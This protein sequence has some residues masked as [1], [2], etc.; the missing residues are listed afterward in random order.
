MRI[1]GIDRELSD[2]SKKGLAWL[3]KKYKAFNS[4]IHLMDQLCK[5]GKWPLPKKA[6]KT[7]IIEIF[8]SKSFWHSHVVGN[9]NNVVGRFPLMVEWLEREDGDLPSDFEVWHMQ[10]SEY[11]FKEL[12]LWIANDG[13]LDKVVKAKLEKAKGKKGKGKNRAKEESGDTEECRMEIDEKVGG[14]KD[15]KLTSSKAKKSHKRK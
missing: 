8:L 10:K 1:L 2:R 7:E 6:S 5:Q 3:Y 12:E 14:S 13:T 15:G 4:A 11:G 9:F